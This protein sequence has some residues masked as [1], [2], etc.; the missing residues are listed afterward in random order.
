MTFL[1]QFDKLTTSVNKLVARIEDR[2]TSG[3]RALCMENVLTS[4]IKSIS[5]ELAQQMS[6]RSFQEV[7]RSKHII[8]SDFNLPYISF[9]RRGLMSLNSLKE[10]VN[11]E[12]RIFYFHFY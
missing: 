8:I 6:P 4:A 2:F 5:R 9:D 12:G 3:D 1:S 10:H 7:L 11:I